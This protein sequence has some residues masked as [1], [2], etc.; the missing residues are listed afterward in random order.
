M[1]FA[2]KSFNSIVSNFVCLLSR[3]VGVFEMAKFEKGTRDLMDAVA[4]ATKKGVTTVIGECILMAA[5]L[6]FGQEHLLSVHC[7]ELLDKWFIC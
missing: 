5:Y 7:L 4:A 3:P 1:S 6:L 2:K